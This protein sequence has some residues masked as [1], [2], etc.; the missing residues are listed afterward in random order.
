MVLVKLLQFPLLLFLKRLHPLPGKRISHEEDQCHQPEHHG[1]DQGRQVI[2][3][4]QVLQG[5][6][7][8]LLIAVIHPQ[9]RAVHRDGRHH[10]AELPEEIEEG[11]R[12]PVVPAAGLHLYVIDGVRISRAPPCRR[13]ILIPR[14]QLI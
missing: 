3:F 2:H 1:G 13:S 6:H 8:A 9:Q 5:L 12:R 14:R 11:I 10:L 4:L 7:R